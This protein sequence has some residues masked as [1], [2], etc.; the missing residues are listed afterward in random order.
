MPEL[1]DP[2]KPTEA[3]VRDAILASIA[4]VIRDVDLVDVPP[5]VLLEGSDPELVARVLAGM[6][7]A[8]LTVTLGK[9]GRQVLEQVAR[10]AVEDLG[11]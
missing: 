3:D 7:G 9:N 2:P 5:A 6:L 1:P 10:H 11:K 4:L 8:V